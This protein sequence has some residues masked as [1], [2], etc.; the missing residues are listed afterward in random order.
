MPLLLTREEAAKELA[1]CTKTID[2]LIT[3]RL[4][5]PCRIGRAVRIRFDQLQRFAAGDHP[6]LAY[7]PSK[8]T[9]KRELDDSTS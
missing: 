3:A 2:N 6:N 9:A 5:K 8:I 4:I 1:V 7:S